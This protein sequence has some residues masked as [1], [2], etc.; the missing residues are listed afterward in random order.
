[1]KSFIIL[2]ILVYISCVSGRAQGEVVSLPFTIEKSVPFISDDLDFRG[3]NQA[4]N[5][6]L[7][8]FNQQN[9]NKKIQINGTT[10]KL[11][12]LKK[13]LESFQRLVNQYLECELGKKQCLKKLNTEVASK[14]NAYRPQ[15]LE[16][17]K[18]YKTNESFFTAYYSPD[19]NG[20]FK[21]TKKFSRPIYGMPSGKDALLT[22][23]EIDFEGK[24]KG[25][26]LE[27]F[28]V[29]ESVY[30]LWLLHV[31]GGGRVKV[32]NENGKVINYYLSYVGTN[33]KEFNMLY[34]Y[35][36]ER[37]MLSEENSGVPA[38]R[39]Y[40]ENNPQDH[41]EILKVCPSYVFFKVTKT[42]PVGVQNIPLTE[43]R[44]LATDYRR[45]KQYGML[46]LV[47]SKKPTSITN[48]N[49]KISFSR[50]FINQDTGGAIKGNGRADMYFG[51]GKYAE[52][53]AYSVA[54][55]GEQ[56]FL[57]LK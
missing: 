3:I 11:A 33:K 10:I 24:L 52:A 39:E 47:K 44:S 36:R 15:I 30:N 16:W 19:L 43:N 4:I 55:L 27:L 42:E 29:D 2:S 45:I 28:Y 32:K 57:I 14:F 6:Q 23:D 13:S 46:V 50:I 7:K 51:Y 20:S 35:M 1:M 54:D 9:L 53:S 56:Y 22:R 17:E 37:G 41:R 48:T 12:K 25:K 38:Q 26:N 21:K 34:H 8:S 31:Q 49:D 18:G 40:F 5:R